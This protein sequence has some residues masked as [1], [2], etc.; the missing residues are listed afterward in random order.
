VSGGCYTKSESLIA[1][2]LLFILALGIHSSLDD[3]VTNSLK[4]LSLLVIFFL[5]GVRV[6]VQ[7]ALSVLDSFFECSL[8]ISG[9]LAFELLRITET[10]LN[11][12]DVVIEGLS[13]VNSLFSELISLFILLS[14]SQHAGNIL[15][16]KSTILIL[17]DDVVLLA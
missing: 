9:N 7:E 13:G 5:F 2:L 8:I 10:G 6:A 1:E 17:N 14:F 15:I 12:V 11:R 16:R 3:G 4:F